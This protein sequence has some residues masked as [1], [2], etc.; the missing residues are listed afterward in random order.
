[1]GDVCGNTFHLVA[2][3]LLYLCPCADGSKVEHGISTAQGW[4]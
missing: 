3:E 4:R 1:M 2:G